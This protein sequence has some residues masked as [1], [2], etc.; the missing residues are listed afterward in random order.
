MDLDAVCIID[1][2]STFPL[3]GTS[4]LGVVDGKLLA[5]GQRICHWLAAPLGQLEG[6]H[7]ENILTCGFIS[8]SIYS[9]F[10]SVTSFVACIR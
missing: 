3:I 4:S 2:P 6:Q 8:L 1:A 10:C 9:I 5:V 7:E